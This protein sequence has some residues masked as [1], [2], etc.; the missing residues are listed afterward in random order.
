MKK[1]FVVYIGNMKK[2]FVVY[3]GNMVKLTHK[4]C[5]VDFAYLI[6]ELCG[7]CFM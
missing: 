5:L 1:L 7:N 6:K 2:L 4:F 3:I